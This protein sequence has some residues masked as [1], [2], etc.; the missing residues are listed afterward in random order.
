MK[1][2]PS[3]RLPMWT[4]YPRTDIVA[5]SMQGLS[6]KVKRPNGTPIRNSKNNTSSA[7]TQWSKQT[8]VSPKKPVEK[9]VKPKKLTK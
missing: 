3:P 9:T 7:N 4:S 5:E 6:P 2:L 1:L 8:I